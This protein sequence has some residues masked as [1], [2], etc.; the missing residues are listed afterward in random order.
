[1]DEKLMAIMGSSSLPPTRGHIDLIGGLRR[2]RRFKRI[3]WCIAGPRP[4]DKPMMPD[5]NPI[6]LENMGHLAIP[7]NWYITGPEVGVVSQAAYNEVDTRAWLL[8]QRMEAL[9]PTANLVDV[10]GS[11][12]LRKAPDNRLLLE[13]WE[14][15]DTELLNRRFFIVPRSGYPQPGEVVLPP[16]CEWLNIYPRNVSSSRVRQMIAEGNPLWETL[17]P[18]L[19]AAYIKAY[20]LFGY[21]E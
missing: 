20:R 11:D 10:I 16:N 7:R 2:D 9:Y 14:K 13:H 1:M 21:H 12:Y 15:W 5:Y 19:V 18:P 8:F 17:V 6:H 4:E 3:L